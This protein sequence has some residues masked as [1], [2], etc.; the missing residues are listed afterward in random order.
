MGRAEELEN[1]HR[2]RLGVPDTR[3]VL[4]VRG[5]QAHL[6]QL[7]LCSPAKRDFPAPRSA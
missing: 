3:T 2:A 5:D 1:V 6:H 4:L 7:R